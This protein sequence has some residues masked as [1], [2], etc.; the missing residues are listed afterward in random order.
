MSGCARARALAAAPCRDR[1]ANERLLCR[2]AALLGQLGGHRS[3]SMV[4]R[5]TPAL[6]CVCVCL[7]GCGVGGFR[8]FFV[9]S[10]G[11]LVVC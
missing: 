1:G 7:S 2:F 8:V 5:C 9:E 3:R 4:Y 6:M 11:K 10:G